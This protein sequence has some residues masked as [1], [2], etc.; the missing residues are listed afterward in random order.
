MEKRENAVQSAKRGRPISQIILR[1]VLGILYLLLNIVFYVAVFLVVKN[2]CSDTYRYAYQIFGN[3]S[4]AEA[5]GTDVSVTIEPGQGT[6]DIAL[7]LERN[8]IVVNRYTFFI[9]TKLTIG[10]EHPIFPGTYTLNTSM[11][12]DDILKIITDPTQNAEEINEDVR[13]E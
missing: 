3:V 12:Y 8:R 9:R 11:C 7:M 10:K 2:L 5:P 1:T 13:Q 4:V 6:M